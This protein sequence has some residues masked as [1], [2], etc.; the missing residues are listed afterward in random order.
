MILKKTILILLSTLLLAGYQ[1]DTDPRTK[2]FP[3]V[4]V[5]AVNL[6][7][8]NNLWVFLL[9]GQSNMAGRGL[10]EP[11]DT[12]PSERIF[13]INKKNEI[14]V[15]K[16]PLHFYEPVLTGLDCGLS[17]G[18]ELLNHVPEGISILL[19]PTAV[20]GSSISQWLGDANYRDVQ[21]FSNFIEKAKIGNE[22]GII[23][24][25]L[26]HQGET[27]ASNPEDRR[28]YK[29]RLLQLTKKFRQTVGDESLP[30]LFGA[31]GSY[32][33]TNENWQAINKQIEEYV[34]TDRFAALIKTS[35]LKHKG[36][37]VHFNAKGQRTLGKRF[38]RAYDKRFN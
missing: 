1:S 37:N 32:S 29:D 36:D 11:Q 23:K 33:A 25:I 10:V 15:A 28:L 5:K 3:K 31:L 30:I 8:K 4:E 7:S 12:I 16:E 24:G 26:W 19:L 9:A 13:T 21:L 20:G 38:A 18:K 17:F 6:P 34:S 22:S 2:Y 35:D 27:D 14:I